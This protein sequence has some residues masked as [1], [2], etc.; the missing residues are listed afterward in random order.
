[1]TCSFDDYLIDYHAL[2]HRLTGGEPMARRPLPPGKVLS[3][4]SSQTT[5]SGA[6]SQAGEPRMPKKAPTN[7]VKG[8]HGCADELNAQ[9]QRPVWDEKRP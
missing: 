4:T 5:L 7:Q 1:M 3:S 2:F 6:K 8:G 9:R